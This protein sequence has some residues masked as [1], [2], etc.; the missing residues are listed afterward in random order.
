MIMT[1]ITV[2]VCALWKRTQN[3]RNNRT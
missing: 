1:G 3:H 2:L